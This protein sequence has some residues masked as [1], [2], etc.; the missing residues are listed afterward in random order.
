MPKTKLNSDSL[1]KL[2]TH[3]K[4]HTNNWHAGSIISALA[5]G[6]LAWAFGGVAYENG[7][8]HE[9]AAH[10]AK[11]EEKPIPEPSSPNAKA[12]AAITLVTSV[13]ITA[14]FQTVAAFFIGAGIGV[15]LGFLSVVTTYFGR[16]KG[17]EAAKEKIEEVVQEQ[18]RA[19]AKAKA[20]EKT[21]ERADG[22]DA[23]PTLPPIDNQ[24]TVAGIIHA[25]KK[26]PLDQAKANTT[27]PSGGRD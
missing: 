7:Y 9:I 11:A 12:I 26:N 2:H 20:E 15:A 17:R 6:G 18:E 22:K 25:G 27:S 8:D 19:E 10:K 1:V 4:E 21:P 5:I 14:I 13:I 23:R 24:G 3:K 16:S